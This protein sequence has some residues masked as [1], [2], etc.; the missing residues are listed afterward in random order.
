MDPQG[1]LD[2]LLARKEALNQEQKAHK[3]EMQDA[4]RH[5]RANL[6][7]QVQRAQVRLSSAE[8]KHRTLRLILMGTYIEHVASEDPDAQERLMH[9]LDRFLERDR[10]RE[11]FDLAPKEVSK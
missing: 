8:R 2:K 3:K 5:Q 1:E 4:Q 10:D 9:G 11:L 6:Q 7:K